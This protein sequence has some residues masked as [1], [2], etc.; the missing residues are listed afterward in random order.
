M[1][2]APFRLARTAA[3]LLPPTI[4]LR[5]VVRILTARAADGKTT[6]RQDG[7]GSPAACCTRF[8]IVEYWRRD[9]VG[10]Q[11]AWR[12]DGSMETQNPDSVEEDQCHS[13]EA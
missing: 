4:R 13:T 5:V 10:Q 8:A 2:V 6:T 1:A 3:A 7:I 9:A 12:P 11:R